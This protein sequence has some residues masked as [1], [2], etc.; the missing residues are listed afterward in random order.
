[1]W[2][3]KSYQSRKEEM[4]YSRRVDVDEI[5]K[6][7]FNPNIS[8]YVSMTEAQEEIDLAAVQEV[9]AGL[10]PGRFTSLN[11]VRLTLLILRCD[12]HLKN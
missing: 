7:D 12:T 2:R 10:E 5:E 9:G 4:R 3:S 8:R 1:L 6:N 11:S